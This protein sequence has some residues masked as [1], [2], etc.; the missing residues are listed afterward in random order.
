MTIYA[1]ALKAHNVFDKTACDYPV[2]INVPRPF[3][4]SN[5][6][7]FSQ[8]HY[9]NRRSSDSFGMRAAINITNDESSLFAIMRPSRSQ[10]PVT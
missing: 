3:T 7:F 1:Q 10:P 6:R 5:V 4:A 8:Q 2:R 9:C